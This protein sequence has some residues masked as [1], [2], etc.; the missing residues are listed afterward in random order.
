MNKTVLITGASSGIGLELSRTFASEGYNLVMVAQNKENLEKAKN[1]ICRDKK[2]TK[3]FTIEKDLS[4]PSAPEEIFEYTKQNFIQ[5][6]ILVNNA[7]I[8][9]YGNFH[10][11][12]MEET[13]NMM[14]LNMVALTK[15]TRLYV[16]GMIERGYGKILNLGSTG[17]F[18]PVPLNTVY[19]ATKAFVLYFS[20]GIGEELKG[21]GVTVTALCPGA[22]ETNFAKRAN[23]E[24]TKLF[25]GKLLKPS[26]VARM[27]YKALMKN[28]RVLVVGL[29]NKIMTLFVRFTPRNIV[30][31][32][33]MGLM[34]RK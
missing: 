10:D 8:Q 34:E 33:G 14:Y 20:E 4:M 3:I 12:N 21:T 19:C 2:D 30:T 28:K 32:F 5:I 31:K 6:D 29:K 13:L 25:S 15:L 11:K 17:S 16:D 26:D 27:G 9:L 22:T 1:I 18:Q 23:I 24:N 7:G